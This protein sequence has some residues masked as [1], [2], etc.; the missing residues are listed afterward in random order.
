MTSGKSLYLPVEGLARELDGKLLLA[1]IARER[2]WHPV[3]GY[4]RAIRD[5]GALL[6]PGVLLSHNARLRKPRMFARMA[7]Y[8]HRTVVLD[9]EALVRQTDEI[10]FLKHDPEAFENVELVL[11]WGEDDA[12]L[13]SR[14]P[15]V[16]DGKVRITGNPRMDI[17]RPELAAYREPEVAEIRGRFG[18]YVLLNSNF[19][20]VNHFVPSRTTLTFSDAA[21]ENCVAG[22]KTAFLEHKRQIFERFLA[23][24]PKIA[25]AIAPAKLIVRPHPSERHDPWLDAV[26]KAANAEVI[27]E[28]SVVPW[29]AGARA[30]VHNGCTSAVEAAVLG[31]TVL[32][33]RPV[34]SDELD[35]PLPNSVGTECFD[36]D[37]LLGE[38]RR[39]LASG[40]QPLSNSQQ[41]LLERHIAAMSGEFACERIIDALEELPETSSAGF[42][43]S[44]ATRIKQRIRLVNR[45]Y[46]K[47][48]KKQLTQGG[49]LR[50]A[51]VDRKMSLM[52]PDYMNQRVERL[53]ETLGRFEGF[54]AKPLSK[55]LFIIE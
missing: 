7:D 51:Y 10:F 15:L 38:L 45:A 29:L 48:F 8:G 33:Y 12:A 32:S 43:R 6:P 23:L 28:G 21:E 1:L 27:S 20:T 16:E 14:S 54:T 53:R 3:I 42:G 24:V 17:L 31:T 22:P 55:N 18:D 34:Q 11:S 39:S 26:A 30:L 9:E 37:A 25:E 50:Q 47:P 40:R 19:P 46:L 13:W 52:T 36:D 49:R 35:N 5:R 4:K 41:A 44:V 2:G